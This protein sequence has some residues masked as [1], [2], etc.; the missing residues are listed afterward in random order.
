MVKVSKKQRTTL[1]EIGKL[2]EER[3]RD[4]ILGLASILVMVLIIVL[5]NTLGYNLGVFDPNNPFIRGMMYITALVFAGFSGIKL[6]HASQK[7]RKIDGFRQQ[8]GIS[9]ETL[10]AWKKG[11]IE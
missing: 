4:R 10:E 8:A 6:M 3:K 9:L 11:E 2:T 5:F 7:Q 1:K